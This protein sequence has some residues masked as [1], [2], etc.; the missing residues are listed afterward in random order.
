MRLSDLVA[1]CGATVATTL[2]IIRIWEVLRDRPRLSTSY[3]FSSSPDH[4]NSIEIL[5]TS[6]VPALITY[7][8]LT[9]A[10]RWWFWTRFDH[11][12][13]ITEEGWCSIT[14]GA[15]DRYTLRFDEDRWFRTRDGIE[16]QSVQLYLK[17]AL[18]N[19]KRMV[20]VKVW[21]P[22]PG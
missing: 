16:G 4:G 14:V 12:E 10:R 7:W 9:W 5:N 13:A 15:H 8:E 17:L 19:R 6:T 3:S 22:H 20:W 2:A 1:A 21:R 18:A 11:L